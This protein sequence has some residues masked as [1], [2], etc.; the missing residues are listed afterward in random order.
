MLICTTLSGVAC[1]NK[2]LAVKETLMEFSPGPS[3]HI[4]SWR[5]ARPS[6]FRG[7]TPQ[8]WPRPRH[9]TFNTLEYIL[10]KKLIQ[11]IQV[12]KWEKKIFVGIRPTTEED[13]SPPRVKIIA[14]TRL[15]TSTRLVFFGYCS[16]VGDS[17]VSLS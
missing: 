5:T 13:I 4:C 12:D 16:S 2:F 7:R 15:F 17:K 1:L 9:G 6:S 8:G 10:D 14:R 3:R 11:H